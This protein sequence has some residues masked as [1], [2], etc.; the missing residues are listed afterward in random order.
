MDTYV[1][2]PSEN[3]ISRVSAQEDTTA[4]MVYNV[5]H[6]GVA[7]DDGVQWHT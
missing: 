6:M 2:D 3:D 5:I 1:C 4:H 7:V